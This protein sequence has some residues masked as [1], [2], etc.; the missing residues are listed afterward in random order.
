MIRILLMRHGSIDSIGRIIYG[1]MPGISLNAEGRRQAEAAAA[2]L[3]ERYRLSLVVSSPMQR[4]VETAKIVAAAQDLD[5]SVEEGLNELDVGEWLG[6]SVEELRGLEE[7]KRYNRARSLYAPP[8]GE[9]LLEV[10]RRSWAALQEVCGRQREGTV[11]AVTHG[12]VIRS[13]LLLF[14]GAP[15]DH[16]LRLE[17]APGSVSEIMLGEGGPL[18]RVVNET[19][20]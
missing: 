6:K 3:R 16:I 15:L 4:T 20:G 12:D 9:S 1:R 18:I 19:F 5:V 7:W 10:Q 17:A 8:G 13:L 14:L 11:L 2:A